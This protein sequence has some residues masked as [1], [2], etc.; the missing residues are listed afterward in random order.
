MT[1]RKTEPKVSDLAGFLGKLAPLDLAE[2][3]DNVGL[4]AGD[5]GEAVRGVVVAIDLGEAALA[6]AERMGA[7]VVVCHHPPIF[8]PALRLT[9]A[10]H[11]FLYEAIRRG[12]GVIALHTNF[13]LSSEELSRKLCDRL[14]FEFQGFLAKRQGDPDV[15]SQAL[16]KFMTY[17]PAQ[18][19][20][21]IREAL[22]KAGAGQIGEYSQ[23][24]FSVEGEGTFLGSQKSNPIKGKRGQLEKTAERRLEMVFPW[25]RR[26]EVVTAARKAHPYDEMA[27]DILKLAQT[28]REIGYG[29][30]GTGGSQDST[31]LVFHKFLE[32]VKETFALCSLTVAGPGMENPQMAVRKM[33][34]SPGS[35][36]A[37]VGAAAAKG[38]DVYVCGELGYHQILEARQKGL[39]VVVLG[40]GNSERFFVETVSDWAG[41]FFREFGVKAG[42]VGKIFETV[43]GVQ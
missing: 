31:K 5:P 35:G 40:H 8:K 33:A 14:G 25:K 27:Y 42:N 6:D 1:E 17:A 24:S 7:N 13:D 39:T 41:N 20:D 3:W 36:S 28:K 23:C 29:L 2:S 4:I 43:H 34:F 16:G 38:V 9:K 19:L 21:V 22:A 12:I 37:F 26:S 18:D 10:T 32:S 11:P 15:P 30:V